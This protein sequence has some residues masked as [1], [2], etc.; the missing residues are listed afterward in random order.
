MA[1]FARFYVI[2][3]QVSWGVMQLPTIPVGWVGIDGVY[4]FLYIPSWI[5]SR[6]SGSD[7]RARTSASW[8]PVSAWNWG[9]TCDACVGA[10]VMEIRVRVAGAYRL[11]YVAKFA[12]GI[13]VL[14]VFQKKSQKTSALDLEI[15]RTRLAAVRRTRK[16]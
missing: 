2:R 7:R 6:S 13:Y 12:E 3:P 5:A 9:P 1:R 8:S 16:E 10:G 4:C 14:H 11:L 15:A